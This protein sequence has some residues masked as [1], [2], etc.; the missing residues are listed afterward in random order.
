M[1]FDKTYNLYQYLSFHDYHYESP[2]YYHPNDELLKT[3][4]NLLPFNWSIN[5]NSVWLHASTP[6]SKEIPIQ[7]WK[8]HISATHRNCVDI[9]KKVVPI[10]ISNNITFK[11]LADRYIVNFTN[12]KT[13]DRGSSGKFITIYPSNEKEFRE[14]IDKLYWNL[15]EFKGPYILS[16]MRYK[17]SN[18]VYYR[19]GAFKE[20]KKVNVLG[21]QEYKIMT[22][23]GE[24]I[25]DNR[26]P[27][28]NL[29]YW[30]K[31]P[32]IDENIMNNTDSTLKD[33]RYRVERVIQFSNTGGVYEGIDLK[34]GNK[35]LIKE[36]R[37]HTFIYA[38]GS[39]AVARLKKEYDLL[40]EMECEGITPKAI[41]LVQEWEHLFLIEEFI[42]GTNLAPFVTRKT[43][44]RLIN[45]TS[46]NFH[47]YVKMVK[48]IW[49][50]IVKG[51]NEFHKRDIIIGDLS[52]LNVMVCENG[53]ISIKF[54]DLEGAWKIGT[55]LP[56]DIRTPGYSSKYD[57]DK[58][59]LSDIYSIGAIMLSTLFPMNQLL[60]L[61][62]SKNEVF[63][64]SLGKR[65]G[66]SESILLLI[67]KCM[68]ENANKRPAI[69]EIQNSIESSITDKITIRIDGNAENIFEHQLNMNE[70]QINLKKIVSNIESSSDYNRRDRLFPS[71]PKVFITNPLNLA[72]G[73]VGVGYALTKINGETSSSLKSWILMQNITNESYSP[74]LYYGLSG[75]AWGL[76]ELGLEE[77]A[78]QVLT[79]GLQHPL[80]FTHAEIYSGA[81]GVGLS[82]LYFYNKTLNQLWLDNAVKIG[83]WL[84][85]SKKE[86]TNGNYYWPDYNGDIWTSYAK[87]SAGI[88]LFLLYL[89]EITGDE[90][91]LVTGK[92]ALE[93]EIS[94]LEETD[95]GFLITRRGTIN[96]GENRES[97]L[98]HYWADGSAGVATAVLRYWSIT[99]QERYNKI[100]QKLLNDA[101]RSITV[102]PNLFKGLS[103]LGNVLI[104]AYEIFEDESYL[105]EA[106]KVA[107]GINLFK[108]ERP[109]GIAYPGEQLLRASTD[110]G[111][112][113]SGI[114]LFLHRLLQANMGQ[115]TTNF[116]FTLDQ[117]IS[118]RTKNIL[119]K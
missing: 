92:R 96:E 37:P 109:E 4:R 32:F 23:D 93:F 25:P 16:D 85:K 112:G 26:L 42:D 94:H 91:Y 72:H 67:K 34:S 50:Q 33:G 52:S 17:D 53:P 65:L 21:Q 99:K 89:S 70:Q 5:R 86:D 19:Y 71:D 7:G 110:F 107:K 90:N 69:K 31:D 64:D 41:D 77:R 119:T 78:I 62:Q 66:L 54:I 105:Y 22:P 46:D 48:D 55:D 76:W 104:D 74:G 102:F 57:N 28:Y 80:L 29:P 47:S 51:V 84:N 13:R 49:L 2:Q 9:L 115:R 59:P 108:I 20:M 40:K 11:F 61:D 3:V 101:K 12:S 87:G 95:E 98:S 15:K 8:I 83:D 36:A 103:G 35:V 43:P 10:L 100:A 24:L 18:V 73:A 118:T 6:E 114:A 79:N 111:T 56:S 106:N 60:E 81:S 38:D 75:I 39:D 44:F 1:V 45:P 58:G 113:S 14:I 116:N 88:S 68:Y 27:Y 82:C 97:V 30:V 117:L 63:I